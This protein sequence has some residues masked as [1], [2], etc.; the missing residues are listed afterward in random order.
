MRIRQSAATLLALLTPS[1]AM[2]QDPAPDVVAPPPTTIPSGLADLHLH[3]FAD[4][5]MAGGFYWGQPDRPLEDFAQ[6]HAADAGTRQHYSARHRSVYPSAKGA[7]QGDSGNHNHGLLGFASRGFGGMMNACTAGIQEWD[8]AGTHFL[9][10]ITADP[11][12]PN[13]MGWP[14]SDTVAHPQAWEGWLRLAHEGIPFA[15]YVDDQLTARGQPIDQPVDQ[16]ELH[17]MLSAFREGNQYKTHMREQREQGR[18]GL[19]TV[20]VSLVGGWSGCMLTTNRR[21]RIQRGRDLLDTR[22]GSY[23]QGQ[24]LI[25]PVL[26]AQRAETLGRPPTS[27]YDWSKD[28]LAA[29]ACDD[30]TTLLLQYVRLAAWAA[31]N[32]D[33]VQLVADGAELQA[34][35]EAGKLAVMVGAESSDWLSGYWRYHDADPT[36]SAFDAIDSELEAFH[37]SGGALAGNPSVRPTI[38]S[39]MTAH[40]LGSAF[41]DPA[42][43]TGSLV[44]AQDRRVPTRVGSNVLTRRSEVFASNDAGDSLNWNYSEALDTAVRKRSSA[45]QISHM[46]GILVTSKKSNRRIPTTSTTAT[47]GSDDRAP[48][49]TA[50]QTTYRRHALGLSPHGRELIRVQ[51][52][53][54]MLIDLAHL[55]DAAVADLR[56]MITEDNG[57]AA[58]SDGTTAPYRIFHSHSI[59]GGI[60]A[61]P[62]E[63]NTAVSALD[64]FDPIIVGIRTADDPVQTDV[65]DMPLG[66]AIAGATTMADVALPELQTAQCQETLANYAMYDTVVRSHGHATALGSDLVGFINHSGPIGNPQTFGSDPEQA[67]C[68]NVVD[69][70]GSEVDTRSIAHVGLAPQAVH[71]AAQTLQPE[72]R[73]AMIAQQMD[74]SRVLWEGWQGAYSTSSP[75]SPE[76]LRDLNGHLFT[77]KG[78]TLVQ[79]ALAADPEQTVTVRL[80]TVRAIEAVLPYHDWPDSSHWP[81]TRV[82]RPALPQLPMTLGFLYGAQNYGGAT[83]PWARRAMAK[84]CLKQRGPDG[85]SELMAQ[86]ESLDARRITG[87]Q[88]G[89]TANRLASSYAGRGAQT[90]AGDLRYRFYSARSRVKKQSFYREYLGD[91]TALLHSLDIAD[92]Q[93]N[94]WLASR[95]ESPLAVT[96]ELRQVLDVTLDV[97]HE[98]EGACAMEP[99]FMYSPTPTIDV[100]LEAAD[101]GPDAYFGWRHHFNRAESRQPAACPGYSQEVEGRCPELSHPYGDL[102]DAC[103]CAVLLRL[104]DEAATRGVLLTPFDQERVSRCEQAFPSGQPVQTVAPAP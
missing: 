86:T 5:N 27:S 53:R 67:A 42:F 76:P 61:I 50:E 70:V 56:R 93:N 87:E 49:S 30:R 78:T 20:V 80:G 23:T 85:C 58:C 36:V 79:G 41:A 77:V 3:M 71:A 69:G 33:W 4:E 47:N 39:M 104:D 6:C 94:G 37:D 99:S 91:G 72:H 51:A 60:N 8:D 9:A 68:L 83:V 63:Q 84:Q 101:V 73:D 90:Y 35:V 18:V 103:A 38:T 57:E 32:D 40:Q 28:D 48:W 25:H 82:E 102:G 43:I 7:F 1:A 92:H 59:P 75:P 55:S 17:T 34:A 16:T 74:S 46:L 89:R 12:V 11:L 29:L 52:C 26:Q 22:F 21:Q 45:H 66:S 2:A 95:P 24:H 88:S 62:R 54:G 31:E 44:R 97:L 64:A 100:T 19:N 98:T 81:H 15:G 65:W 14:T 13:F 10:A 96:D